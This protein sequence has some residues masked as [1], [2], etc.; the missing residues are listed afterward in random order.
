MGSS[1]VG[2]VSREAF[3]RHE[4]SFSVSH[5]VSQWA[6]VGGWSKADGSGRFAPGIENRRNAAHNGL[7]VWVGGC[8]SEWVA[9]PKAPT[10][11]GSKKGQ[12]KLLIC[13]FREWKRFDGASSEFSGVNFSTRDA[14]SVEFWMMDGLSISFRAL[15]VVH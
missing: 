1:P 13:A 14:M 9:S 7:C 3:E 6:N 4:L 12:T 11:M 10:R 5:P 15:G 8:L 2:N